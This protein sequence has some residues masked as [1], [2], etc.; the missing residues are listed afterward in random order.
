[1]GLDMIV[2][3]QKRNEWEELI[4][5]THEKLKKHHFYLTFSQFKNDGSY[6][7]AK[8]NLKAVYFAFAQDTTRHWVELEL[9]KRK[10]SKQDKLYDFIRINFNR[11]LHKTSYPITWDKEDVSGTTR[12]TTSNVIRIK[13]YINEKN[14]EEWSEAMIELVNSF[15][16]I[17]NKGQSITT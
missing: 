2:D 17:L 4:E 10:N 15:L 13:I 16:P 5:I 12:R 6:A 11:K 7:K 14:K 1:M 9:R 3:L 8:T